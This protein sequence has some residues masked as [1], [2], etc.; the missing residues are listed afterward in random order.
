MIT[1]VNTVLVS[2]L[3]SSNIAA[4]LEGGTNGQYI[5][6][7]ADTNAV[8]NTTAKMTTAVKRIKVGMFTG[9]TNK[10]IPVIRWS[11]II[12]RADIKKISTLTAP[13]SNA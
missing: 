4:T 2:N 9:E 8:I 13:V 5:V 10:S 6:V 3:S 1:Y 7:D 12:N 11:N